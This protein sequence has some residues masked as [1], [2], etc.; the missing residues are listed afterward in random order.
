[1]T[2]RRIGR[3]YNYYVYS[4]IK[5]VILS[6][7]CIY[8][9][10]C[11]HRS[12][13]VPWISCDGFCPNNKRSLA[14]I[15]ARTIPGMIICTMFS[16]TSRKT[17]SLL[18]MPRT[19][20]TRHQMFLSLSNQNG[21]LENKTERKTKKKKPSGVYVR[22]SGAIERGSGFFV[23]GLEGSR[24]RLVIGT[25]LLGL[26]SFNHVLLQ[27]GNTLSNG[28]K[29]D[30]FSFQ[31]TLAIGYSL[32]ILFQSAIEFVKERRQLQGDRSSSSSSRIS[33]SQDM[34]YSNSPALKQEWTTIATNTTATEKD[35]SYRSKIA[36]A[37]VAYMSMTPTQEIM[38]LSQTAKDDTANSKNHGKILY[39]LGPE[40][41]DTD[42]SRNV[43][44]TSDKI[45]AGVQAALQELQHS[46]SGRISL[47]M[48]H[49]AVQALVLTASN[50]NN[51]NNS[52]FLLTTT[53]TS[54]TTNTNARTVILQRI[55]NNQCWMVVSNQLLASYTLGDLKWLGRMAAYVA[56]QQ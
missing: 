56:Q 51:N 12:P 49:P 40:E 29:G 17:M 50:N 31:E 54:T 23:P 8:C 43:V 30:P 18:L 6:I 20:S 3:L 52:S 32:L 26:T 34:L 25:V 35:L 44:V 28:S 5:H 14:K 7:V 19:T 4:R 16:S 33:S 41:T 39:R 46:K 55:K 9:C 13:I 11:C 36:W 21:N 24:V 53:T 1:M 47:P 37:A 2:S 45:A 10:Y 22:P 42:L 15:S 38:L 48:T 27:R